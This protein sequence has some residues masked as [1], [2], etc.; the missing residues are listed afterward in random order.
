M[1]SMNRIIGVVAPK[2][3]G[4]SHQVTTDIFIPTSRVVIYDPQAA[5]D[6]DYRMAATHIVERDIVECCKI[7][8]QEENFKILFAPADPVQDG[9]EWKFTDFG[10]LIMKCFRYCE[11]VPGGMTLVVDE[12]HFTCSKRTMPYELMKVTTTSR[13]VGLNVVW[14]T[15]KFSGVNTWLRGN[16]DEYWLFRLASPGDLDIVAQVCGP[17][18]ED[19]IVSLRRLDN[20]SGALVPGQML[21]WSSLDGS[22]TIR[23]LAEEQNVGSKQE[24]RDDRS[25]PQQKIPAGQTEKRR[26]DEASGSP[27]L[28]GGTE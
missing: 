18:V 4:K 6:T 3:S 1:A 2:G 26:G 15:Q 27:N 12:A 28:F 10:P 14:V 8:G 7:M 23:D 20:S 11:L 13:A 9:D 17:E 25:T 16:A 22:V 19:Q 5:R 21:V 24:S